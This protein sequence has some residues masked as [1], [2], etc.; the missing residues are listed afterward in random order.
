MRWHCH[1][2]WLH[3]PP[4]AANE[5][6]QALVGEKS[7]GLRCCVARNAVLTNQLSDRGNRPTRLQFPRDDPVPQF[8]RE[9]PIDRLVKLRCKPSERGDLL[10][11]C[12]LLKPLSIRPIEAALGR[13]ILHI[14]RVGAKEEM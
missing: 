5:A 10:V 1:S 14:V 6:D 7:N 12:H 13:S 4:A 8:S 2:V 11:K 3:E 9:L